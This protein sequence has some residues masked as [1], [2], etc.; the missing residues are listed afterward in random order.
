[1][2]WLMLVSIV[3]NELSDWGLSDFS[4]S[5]YA[6]SQ[7]AGVFLGSYFWGSMADKRGRMFA[8]K[9]TLLVCGLGGCVAACS[10][11]FR[12]LC[13]MAF[14]VG[15]GVGGDLA[16]DGTVFIEFCPKSDRHMLTLMSAVCVLGSMLVPALAYAY[17]ILGL[18]ST[19]RWV[20][21]TVSVLNLGFALMR[22][23]ALETPHY[24]LARGDV[25]ST[26]AILEQLSLCNNCTVASLPVELQQCHQT[27]LLQPKPFLS[28]K[29]QMARLFSSRLRGTTLCFLLIWFFTAFTFSGFG[30]FMPE[31][32][33]R[34]GGP[35]HS[36]DAD[37]YIA[38][39]L[40]QGI[41]VISVLGATVGVKSCLGRKWTQ[42]LALLASSV[43]MYVFLF[44]FAYWAVLLCSTSFYLFGLVAFSVQYTY[45]PESF[46]A[47]V[48]NTGVGFCSAA[49]RL[50]SIVS[51]MLAGALLD[52]GAG[53]AIILYSA[54]LCIA[55]LLG[56]LTKET[57]GADIEAE[58]AL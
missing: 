26:N 53:S 7:S 40:Q 58:V 16:V 28:L 22:R 27:L 55:G 30:V 3:L 37:V 46:P 51:P 31:F 39:T 11:N 19:W 54:S 20:M 23:K 25:E 56:L 52:R 57:K 17:T 18:T 48:R 24:Y 14:V 34:A 33:K 5:L 12:M 6:M 43:F 21:L 10:V 8:F 47:D 15:I 45:T 42:S 49:N 2:M 1:M 50:A 44:P 13:F 32:L 36:S 35:E 41:G 9:N 38:M 29:R 4:L